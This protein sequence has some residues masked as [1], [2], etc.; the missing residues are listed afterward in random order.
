ME[1][2]AEGVE[3]DEQAVQLR[4]LTCEYGQGYLFSKP[5]N[6]ED[7][8]ALIRRERPWPGGVLSAAGINERDAARTFDSA[9]VM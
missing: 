5:L 8:G 4:A 9:L 6:K 3:T 7:A 2:V 1:V